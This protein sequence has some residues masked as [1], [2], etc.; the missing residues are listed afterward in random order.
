[1]FKKLLLSL[2]LFTLINNSF[3]LLST[4]SWDQE[5]VVLIADKG[6]GI[7]HLDPVSGK[8]WRID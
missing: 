6:S 8:Y 5:E 4:Q 2:P 1:M 3:E 7:Y